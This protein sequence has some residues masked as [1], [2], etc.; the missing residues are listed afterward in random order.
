MSEILEDDIKGHNSS[1]D[2]WEDYYA[3][4]GVEPN[5]P[6]KAL[7]RAYQEVIKKTLHRKALGED[8]TEDC[9]QL[10]RLGRILLDPKSRA[11]YD[12][13][14]KT[15]GQTISE[16][17]REELLE[18]YKQAPNTVHLLSEIVGPPLWKMVADAV[19]VTYRKLFFWRKE[20]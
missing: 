8:V 2:L 5:T 18:A 16:E 14:Y 17:L 4:L 12:E 3:L 20:K 10:D 6:I 19:V 15:E 13:A 11:L 9:L 1:L 7:F